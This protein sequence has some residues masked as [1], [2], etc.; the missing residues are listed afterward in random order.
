MKKR[1][2]LTAC[3]VAGLSAAPAMAA[4]HYVSGSIGMSWFNDSDWTII[5]SPDITDKVSF[6]SGINLLGAVGC[7]YGSYRLEA[8]VGYQ[9]N[10]F[11][12]ISVPDEVLLPA[13]TAAA[14]GDVSIL[15]LMANGYYDIDAGGFEPYL[16]AGVGVAQVSVKDLANEFIDEE[17]NAYSV[18]ETTLAWQVGAG[19]AVPIGGNVKLDA[20]YR[21]FSLT[22]FSALGYDINGSSH[23][24]LLGLRVGF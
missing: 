13:A 3:L 7:D 18:S 19:V 21:Y 17:L 6:D 9:Q 4:D 15:S 24:V 11:D 14:E 10:D 2:L 12:A 5:G 22:D 8:E 20:R 16:S 1:F 23:N